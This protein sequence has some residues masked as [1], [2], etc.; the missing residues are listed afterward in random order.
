MCRQ[1]QVNCRQFYVFGMRLAGTICM[2]LVASQ[3]QLECDWRLVQCQAASFLK[4]RCQND[5]FNLK[6]EEAIKKSEK[7]CDICISY[8]AYLLTLCMA[9]SNLVRQFL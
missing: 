7:L 8:R 5:Y 4:A 1:S 2:R 9:R 3:V 6:N